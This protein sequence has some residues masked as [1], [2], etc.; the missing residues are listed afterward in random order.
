MKKKVITIVSIAVAIALIAV[1]VLFSVNSCGKDAAETD[2]NLDIDL[3][4]KPE[5]KALFPNSGYSD[6]QMNDDVNAK[7]IEELTGYK[8]T[9]SQ[10][11]AV[12]PF[13]QL[14]TNLI[15]REPF[16]LM[17][18][19]R[20]QFNTLIAQD[21]L[22]D[23]TP[24]IEKFGPHLKEAIS[25]ESWGVVTV[26]GK[27]YGIPERA[28][29]DNIEKPIVFRQDWLDKLNLRMPTTKEEFRNVLVQLK[30]EYGKDNPAFY[31]L[32][33]DKFSPLLYAVSPAFG[34]YSDWQEYDGQV[35]YYFEAPGMKDYMDFMGELYRDG[36]IDLEVDT[37]DAAKAINKFAKGEA[38]AIATSLWSV[39]AIVESLKAN[40]VFDD[41][42]A[43]AGLSN[44]LGYLR[45]LKNPD[46][47]YRCFRNGGYSYI[48]AVPFYMAENAGY[49]VDWLDQKLTDEEGAYNFRSIVL[50]TEGVHY[51]YSAKDDSYSPIEANFG[52]KDTASF[53]LTGSNENVYTKYW[54]ARVKKNAEMY[55]AWNLL[56]KDADEVGVYSVVNFAP[57]LAVYSEKSAAIEQN[58]MDAVFVML[59]TD[60]S[61]TNYQAKLTA[62]K[63]DSGAAV[64]EEINTWYQSAK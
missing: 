20:S 44:Y 51:N 34:I 7:L 12:E 25:D 16:N 64:T 8:V 29:S 59:R 36:L 35:K 48:T 6:R 53:Y 41:A 63:N 60:K 4:N 33:F 9:Y 3:G 46:G 47:E 50:G 57:P 26:N 32:T 31:P 17:K 30:A 22:T 28:S 18:L 2:I 1:I 40:G 58:A 14:N 54:L 37:N 55:R 27:I 11:P 5:L 43:Q 39:P 61:G 21:A 15:S 45:G 56:M 13:T 24:A 10:L 38:G 62:W 23:L 19:T 52:E 49:V 42:Q